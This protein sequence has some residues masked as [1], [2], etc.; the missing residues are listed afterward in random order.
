MAGISTAALGYWKDGDSIHPDYD[1]VAL[2]DVAKLY[3]KYESL[4]AKPVAAPE[5]K[6]CREI[7]QLRAFA[8]AVMGDWPDVGGLDGFDLQELGVKH[9]LLVGVMKHGPCSEEYCRCAEDGADFPGECFTK[10]P[11]LNGLTIAAQGGE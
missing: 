9:G 1:T 10:T 3:A 7:D 11:L 8:Q 4:A 2:R 5:G 6:P